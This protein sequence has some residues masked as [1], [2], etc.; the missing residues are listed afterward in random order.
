MVADQIHFGRIALEPLPHW[1]FFPMSHQVVA[2]RNTR[3]GGLRIS[4]AWLDGAPP[5]RS[6]LESLRLA[7]QILPDDLEDG[8]PFQ[9]ERL[10]W[11][12]GSLCG[13]ASVKGTSDFYRIWYVHEGTNLVAALYACKLDQR[14]SREAMIELIDCRR[15]AESITI[16]SVSNPPP[17]PNAPLH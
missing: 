16:L 4:T 11:P 5:A 2:R 8:E 1:R 15:L 6:H 7:A 12:P 3:C 14:R 10:R 17:Q 9:I 13:G